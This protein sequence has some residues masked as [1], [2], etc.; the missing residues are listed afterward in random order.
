MVKYK[1]EKYSVLT[2]YEETEVV[3]STAENSSYTNFQGY[4]DYTVNQ[5]TGLYS[6]I[7]TVSFLSTTGQV[8]RFGD[9]VNSTTLNS[10]TFRRTTRKQASSNFVIYTIHQII[11]V[12]VKQ[13]FIEIV[14]A[15]DGTYPDNGAL[16]EYWYVKGEKAAPEIAFN[17]NGAI[18]E[19]DSGWVNINGELREIDKMWTRID[20]VLRE[21]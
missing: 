13:N 21:V 18:K 7:G 17:I 2:T 9:D 15:E 12:P 14:V 11:M 19:M 8:S 5:N 6:A 10:G 1:Y 3:P 20:D 4:Q 16:G